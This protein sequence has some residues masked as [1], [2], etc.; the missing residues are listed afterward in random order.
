MKF[1]SAPTISISISALAFF[2]AFACTLPTLTMAA[3]TAEQERQLD[4]LMAKMEGD[5]I[6]LVRRVEAAYYDRC[7]TALSNCANNNYDG[8]VSEFPNPT[9]HRS[10]ELAIDAC[11]GASDNCA[12]LF[13]FTTSNIRLPDSVNAR[14][15]QVSTFRLLQRGL[16]DHIAACKQR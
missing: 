1:R 12:A 7:T 6:E 8:C 2:F 4:E 10:K 9:C 13:D 11:S 5:V 3:V 15:P 14:D 16:S